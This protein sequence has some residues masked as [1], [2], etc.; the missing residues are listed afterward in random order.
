MLN[1]V[2]R[3]GVIY[4]VILFLI[5]FYSLRPFVFGLGNN[6]EE[7]PLIYKHLGISQ[8]PNDE[9]VNYHTSN[10]SQV[11]PYVILVS[12][13]LKPFSV[14]NFEYV[15]FMLNALYLALLFIVLYKIQ[16]LLIRCSPRFTFVSLVGFLI[17]IT[18]VTII[19]NVR[20]PFINFFD[21]EAFGFL[22]NF[23]TALTLYKE[24]YILSILSMA[25]G[26]VFHPLHTLPLLIPL[27]VI[28]IF[29]IRQGL[30][31]KLK[32]YLYILVN[33]FVVGLYNSFLW[34]KSKQT[35][36]PSVDASAISEIIRSPHH[37]I[38][39]TF[40]KMDPSTFVFYLFISILTISSI[41][42][43][44][45]VLILVDFKKIYRDIYKL[46]T[47]VGSLFSRR[48]IVIKK[49]NDSFV[50]WYGITLFN[51]SLLSYLV[52]VSFISTFK[53][54]PLLI[55]ITPYRIG[56][57]IVVQ[58]WILFTSSF[59]YASHLNK[60]KINRK[61]NYIFSILLLV[62]PL[63]AIYRYSQRTILPSYKYELAH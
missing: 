42:I 33:I 53:R 52:L 29:R 30:I 39:P 56:Y 51:F 62:I 27:S 57:L 54:I 28:L 3:L 19:P 45:Y 10:Y 61:L 40:L 12:L 25:L 43:I 55:Q 16:Q 1:K 15:F 44:R 5:F 60:I 32:G 46:S 59:Y 38:I 8:Y 23:I 22:F 7:L 2:T 4:W 31:S 20:N 17:I 18:I 35:I 6:V 14:S 50:T 34:L 49:N 47:K 9:Y 41:I 36:L 21:P 24:K 63:L 58:S 48:R 37:H 26:T 11:T 13:I